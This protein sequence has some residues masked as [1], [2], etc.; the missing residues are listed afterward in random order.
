MSES[1]AEVA[2]RA[3][4]E[5][6]IDRVRPALVADGGDCE[7]LDVRDGVVTLRLVGACGACPMAQMTLRQGIE[8]VI[9][10]EIPEVVRVE[11]V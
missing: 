3:R 2:L 9:R 6:A 11:A 7:V 4:V 10:D 1:A 5:A 8:R